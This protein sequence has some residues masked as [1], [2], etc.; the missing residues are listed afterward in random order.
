MQNEHSIKDFC[1]DDVLSI[2]PDLTE[3]QA[4]E[5]LETVLNNDDSD[6][7]L[8]AETL[9][10]WAGSMFPLPKASNVYDVEITETLQLCLTV[11]AADISAAIAQV[12]EAYHNGVYVLDSS[13]FMGAEFTSPDAD[14]QAWLREMEV[15]NG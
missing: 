4:F 15:L 5:V 8:T 9:E 13:H 2:R 3:E 7:G 1:T 12:K 6:C 11:K 10:F 14:E